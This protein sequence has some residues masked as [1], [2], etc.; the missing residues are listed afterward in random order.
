MKKRTLFVSNSSTTSFVLIGKRVPIHEADFE[1]K[2]YIYVGYSEYAEG[3]DVFDVTPEH[4]T[5]FPYV[6]SLEGD[7]WE[8]ATIVFNSGKATL[9]AGTYDIEG[10]EASYYSG[11]K[12]ADF[13]EMYK[14]DEIAVALAI[15][16]GEKV[17]DFILDKVEPST[18][19]KIDLYLEGAI[20]EQ[21]FRVLL[22][23]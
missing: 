13:L 17:P 23:I 19:R 2:K 14:V 15:V 1:N 9:P 18:R 3:Q 22:D 20:N 21:A 4:V 5:A 11:A 16:D 7:L 8:N 12:I 6:S 10:G